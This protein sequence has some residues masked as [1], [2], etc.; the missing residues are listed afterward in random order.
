MFVGTGAASQTACTL[1]VQSRPLGARRNPLVM[2]TRAKG[3]RLHHLWMLRLR[4]CRDRC[5]TAVEDFSIV[6]LFV[7]KERRVLIP[8]LY[9]SPGCC[10][11]SRPGPSCFEIGRLRTPL[12]RRREDGVAVVPA[13]RRQPGSRRAGG[14]VL[15]TRCT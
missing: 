13:R 9:V 8:P 6:V 2:P 5:P 7:R 1:A 15:S 14:A 10:L 11:S 12:A 3:E 4:L